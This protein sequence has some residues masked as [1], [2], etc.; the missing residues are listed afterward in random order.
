[1]RDRQGCSHRQPVG[2]CRVSRLA[3]VAIRAGRLISWPRMLAGRAMAWNTEAKTPAARVRLCAIAARVSQAA[4]AA[5]PT[6]GAQRLS[7]FQVGHDLFDD[8]VAAVAGLVLQHPQWGV[9]EHGVVAVARRGRA[10][11]P[12]AAAS[13]GARSAGPLPRGSRG[14]RRRCSRLRRPRRRR[15]SRRPGRPHRVRIADRRPRL[16]PD[17]GDRRR[18]QIR[19]VKHHRSR[20]KT[21]AELY[22]TDA[23]PDLEESGCPK[24]NSPSRQG[25][26][27]VTA[28]SRNHQTGGSRLS[29]SPINTT[30]RLGYSYG[31]RRYTNSVRSIKSQKICQLKYSR[32]TLFTVKG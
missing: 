17:G 2:R 19:I 32:G 1:M 28:R 7:A 9:G 14:R 30:L 25:H 23:L 15:P 20:R 31:L 13:P 26:L 16:V 24:T 22:F 29:K 18:H 5:P 3:E 12:A 11:R 6:A 4:L 10:G 27:A 8:G 21:M